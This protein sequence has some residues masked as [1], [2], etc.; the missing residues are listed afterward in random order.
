MWFRNRVAGPDILELYRTLL[1][2]VRACI[3]ISV[4][5]NSAASFLSVA[6]TGVFAAAAARQYVPDDK[7]CCCGS[8][9]LIPGFL[10]H[11]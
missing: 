6:R 3:C 9:H 10:S 4:S 5:C 1:Y 11:L 2:D 7:T 8:L